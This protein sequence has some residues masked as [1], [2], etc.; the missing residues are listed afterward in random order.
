M[1]K[2][3]K[4]MAAGLAAGAVVV[5]GGSA[6]YAFWSTTGTGS[7]PSTSSA[8]PAAVT[9]HST[10]NA[11]T[12]APGTTVGVTYSATNSSPTD[13]SVTAPTYTITS[14]KN[15]DATHSCAAFLSL[16]NEPSTAGAGNVVPHKTT[17]DGTLALGTATLSFANSTTVDQS[18][19]EGQ[20]VTIAL[21][22]S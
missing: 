22:N 3:N 7:D 10:F 8:T 18:A 4:K 12:L 6:A 17:S 19:C 11:A 21:S 2:F 9:Y 5:A 20:T 16:D 1:R 15:Y 13:L 14:D